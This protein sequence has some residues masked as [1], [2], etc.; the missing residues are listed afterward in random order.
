M[1]RTSRADKN[2]LS[3]SGDTL[4]WFLGTD[5]P[6]PC[7][8]VPKEVF[9]LDPME[10]DSALKVSINPDVHVYVERIVAAQC[11]ENV[12]D[13][14]HSHG[15]TFRRALFG[16]R[17]EVGEQVITIKGGSSDIVLSGTIGSKGINAMVV[18]GQWSDQST[19]LSRDIDLSELRSLDGSPITVI[20]ARVDRKTVKLPPG[21]RVLFWKSLVY[22]VYWWLKRGA[23]ALHLLG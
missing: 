4:Q 8:R 22:T 15:V 2:Y 14:N 5:Y 21:A 1:S 16:R 9:P 6:E 18:L 11:R 3:W 7:P 20:M 19:A 12:L 17:G 10:W 13:I 23:V